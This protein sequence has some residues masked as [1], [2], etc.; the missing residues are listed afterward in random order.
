MR[1]ATILLTGGSG[2][3]GHAFVRYALTQGASR[4][5]AMSRNSE[6]R[7]KLQQSS[8]SAIVVPGDVRVMSDIRRAFTVA[9]HVDIVIH[10]AAEKHITTAQAFQDY[11]YDVNVGGAR[12]LI[13]VALSRGVPKVVA[14]S[15][16]KACE[17]INY[18]G[19]TKA[20]AERLFV[21]AGYVCV[22]YGN[23]I[24]SSGSVIPLFI[25]QRIS[26]RIT[27]TDL[28]MTRFFMPV[29][30]DSPWMAIQE[31]GSR[32]VMSAVELVNYAIHLGGGGEIFIP[33][34][35][36]GSI[37]DLAGKVGP[38]CVIEEVG[39]REG[40][41]LHE[42]LVARDEVCRT[43]R[44]ADG[45]FAVLSKPVTYLPLVEPTFQHTSDVDPQPIELEEVCAC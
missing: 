32:R 7:Y 31:P 36:S 24:G 40:E 3:F 25:Q 12:H 21:S 30:P 13:D 26:G 2:T 37:A 33:S 44:C 43:Y 9:G 28:R 4:I 41:K 10:A 27:V 45:I 15:T 11:T 19:Q 42:I 17:P 20:E 6:M 22:R 18:Y 1:D 23:V 39:M 14:L 29:A 34:I 35:P 16:D 38:G 8:S 5:V